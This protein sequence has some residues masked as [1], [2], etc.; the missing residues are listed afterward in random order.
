MDAG[1]LVRLNPLGGN[2]LNV[3]ELLRLL[4]PVPST[5]SDDNSGP[6]DQPEDLRRSIVDDYDYD[7]DFI[8]DDDLIEEQPPHPLLS[9][10]IDPLDDDNDDDFVPPPT[11]ESDEPTAPTPS[12]KEKPVQ[13]QTVHHGFGRFFVNRGDIPSL[14]KLKP[15]PNPPTPVGNVHVEI[16]N[17]FT[18]PAPPRSTSAP[19]NPPQNPRKSSPVSKPSTPPPT[20]QAPSTPTS[21]PPAPPPKKKSPPENPSSST[22]P[23]SKS[24][25]PPAV[26]AEITKLA[27]LCQTEFGDK[28]PKLQ[29]SRIQQQ[30]AVLF[31]EAMSAGVARLFSDIAKDKRTLH[32]SDDVWVRLSRFLRTKRSTLE[33]LG[34]ALHWQSKENDAK[35]RVEQ[36]ERAVD[37]VMEAQRAALMVDDGAAASGT[38]LRGGVQWTR[39]LDE[40]MFE[41]YSAKGELQTAKNQLGARIRSIKKAFPGWIAALKSRSFGGFVVTEQELVDSVRRIEE[42]TA[43]KERQKR[44]M[45]RMER[46]RRKEE[47]AA[48]LAAKRQATAS[49]KAALGAPAKP[50]SASGKSAASA[51][52]G[53]QGGNGGGKAVASSAG[54][55]GGNKG[56]GNSGGSK[57]TGNG[58]AKTLSTSGG[59]KNSG[60]V[61]GKVVGNANGDKQTTSAGAKALKGAGAKGASSTSG[62]E[63]VGSNKNGAPV[64]KGL[65]PK[66]NKGVSKNGGKIAQQKSVAQKSQKNGGKQGGSTAG[67]AP[68]QGK[69]TSMIRKTSKDGNS[70]GKKVMS[71]KPSK[72]ASASVGAIGN[73]PKTGGSNGTETRRGGRAGP[74]SGYKPVGYVRPVVASRS[75]AGLKPPNLETDGAQ[76][77]AG[78]VHKSSKTGGGKTVSPTKGGGKNGGGKTAAGKSGVT[79]VKGVAKAGGIKTG[80][81]NKAAGSKA[82]TSRPA[83]T[84]SKVAPTNLPSSSKSVDKTPSRDKPSGT[85]NQCDLALPTTPSG[86]QE[87]RATPPGLSSS[88]VSKETAQ[89]KSGPPQ[90]VPRSSNAEAVSVA[91]LILQEDVEPGLPVREV[92]EL[93]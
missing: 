23:K 38:E 8:D 57:Q 26:L 73:G 74:G 6:D 52:A 15:P 3:R 13:P 51:S 64:G 79:Q 9:S 2:Q 45:E 83:G 19:S 62:G 31:R 11:S 81:G 14:T 47:V 54:K 75:S 33:A 82:G 78:K 87:V 91:R 29:D 50:S 10:D 72:T 43:A 24:S 28:K 41:W 22:A 61:A 60:N 70:T 4:H 42:E 90:Q 5:P 85:E 40:V 66:S 25:L 35:R 59:G 49:A 84:N 34:H 30:L 17:L 76:G 92:I 71:T 69:L 55:H 21:A 1:L 58:T 7:D 46:K 93:D 48:A 67:P 63:N 27:T 16:P 77:A 86:T 39:G 80:G 36:A 68:K 53:K 37:A 18:S 20:A 56:A 88:D 44:E 65:T 32:V 12:R 89:M